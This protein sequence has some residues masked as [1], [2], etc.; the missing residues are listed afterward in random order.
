MKWNGPDSWSL[1]RFQR[2]RV[3]FPGRTRYN[4]LGQWF[5]SMGARGFMVARRDN[6]ADE[7]PVRTELV[8]RVRQ[9]IQIGVYETEEKLEIAL[10]RLLAELEEND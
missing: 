6:S 10:R 1:P 7:P 8:A 3:G 4:W 5:R 2:P 9:E